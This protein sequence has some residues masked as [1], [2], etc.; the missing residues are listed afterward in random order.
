MTEAQSAMALQFCYEIALGH[1]ASETS[2]FGA[3]GIDFRAHPERLRELLNETLASRQANDVESLLAI[4]FVFGA[5][6]SEAVPVLCLLLL[7]DYHTRH[8]DVALY[9]QS[10]RDP[11]SIAAL[12]D[13]CFLDLPYFWDDGDAL[14][15]KCTWALHDIGTPEAFERLH[16]LTDHPRSSVVDYAR[17]RLVTKTATS[18]SAFNSRHSEQS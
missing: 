15:R 18:Q 3:F 1:H 16:A 11:R 13:A 9:L 4:S 8:E 2:L 14:A 17:K 10:L 5:L 12:Y 7:A 6:T